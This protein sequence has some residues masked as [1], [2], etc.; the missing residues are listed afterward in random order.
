[1]PR[2][3]STTYALL[4]LLALRPW[5]AYE[6]VGQ[7]QR[8]MRFFWPRSEAHVYSEVK[9]LV[10]LGWAESIEETVGKRRRTRYAITAPG[11]AAL[12]EWLGTAPAAPL[13]EIE[14]LLRVFFADQG[15]VEQLIGSLHALRDQARALD[16]Q[17]RALMT[18]IASDGGPFPERTHLF[19]P[20]A[21]LYHDLLTLLADWSERTLAEVQTWESTADGHPTPAE[22]E[23]LRRFDDK[24]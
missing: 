20:L 21:E 4:G 5:T 22:V 23:R 10:R 15:S 6:L 24:P 18:E 1:M 19:L 8:S 3:S 13:L 7:T 16:D 11:R 9:R 12:G 17:G 2:P 14:A